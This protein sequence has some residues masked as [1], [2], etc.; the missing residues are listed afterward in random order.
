MC[1]YIR[2]MASR[3]VNV[4]EHASHGCTGTAMLGNGAVDPTLSL[5]IYLSIYLQ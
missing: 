2:L 1:A 3:V 4:F 5:Y